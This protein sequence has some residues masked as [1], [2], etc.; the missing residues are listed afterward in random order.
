[1][2]LNHVVI[3]EFLYFSERLM[4]ET[5]LYIETESKHKFIVKMYYNMINVR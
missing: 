5:I 2:N 3:K 4:P 1:M